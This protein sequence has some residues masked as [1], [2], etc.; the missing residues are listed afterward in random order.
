VAQL[1]TGIGNSAMWLPD[2]GDEVIVA[3]EHGDLRHPV[4]IG[5]LWNGKD[6]PPSPLP[7][8]QFRSIFQS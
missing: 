6:L 3:F 5:S 4:V 7:A 8:T 1:A 2:V